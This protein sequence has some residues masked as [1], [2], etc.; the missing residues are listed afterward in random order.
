[1]AN[2]GALCRSGLAPRKG[3]TFRYAESRV[4]Y[5]SIFG[6]SE[7]RGDLMVQRHDAK[8]QRHTKDLS[9]FP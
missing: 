8:R 5:G 1:M 3:M 4:I 7:K 6:M 9:L 2:L